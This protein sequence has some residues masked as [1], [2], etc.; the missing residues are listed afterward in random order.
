MYTAW[1]QYAPVGD[2]PPIHVLLVRLYLACSKA[3]R[4]K[5]AL[6]H[7]AS[8]CVMSPWQLVVGV[9]RLCTIMQFYG[10]IYNVVLWGPTVPHG[11]AVWNTHSFSEGLGK[12]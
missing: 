6:L 5:E 10:M 2:I 8:A 9:Y 7:T 11:Y 3:L 4:E 1:I 12:G